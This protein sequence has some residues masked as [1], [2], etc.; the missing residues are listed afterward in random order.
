MGSAASGGKDGGWKPGCPFG[1]FGPFGLERP[2]PPGYAPAMQERT[3]VHH[4]AW[5]MEG[6]IQ[7]PTI[8]SS[9]SL[10]SF[11]MTRKTSSCWLS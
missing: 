4:F 7:M 8:F 3:A 10:L 1:P 2:L 11:L 6:L 9:A 5:T